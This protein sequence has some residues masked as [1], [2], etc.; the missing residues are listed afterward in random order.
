MAKIIVVDDASFMCNTLKYIIERM[1][2]E[3]V[4]SAAGYIRKP[5]KADEVAVE[6][7]RALGGGGG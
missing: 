4:A 6:I 2:H 3:I 1:G 7:S 5:F